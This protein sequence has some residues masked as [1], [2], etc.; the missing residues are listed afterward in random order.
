[1]RRL[2]PNALHILA[3]ISAAAISLAPLSSLAATPTSS[4]APVSP[5]TVKAAFLLNFLRF[6]DWPASIPTGITP[7]LIG[8]S[9]DRGLEDELLRLADRQLLHGRRLR[10][11]R[12]ESPS[13][14]AGLH[15][16]YF[17]VDAA[18]QTETLPAAEALSL[19]HGRPVLTVSDSANFIAAGG[20][21][22][23]FRE[24][25]ALRFEI[26]PDAARQAGLVLSSRLLALANIHREAPPVIS[27]HP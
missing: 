20:M 21:I 9:G 23:I 10:V 17:D 19:L 6:T 22:R 15:M 2:V 18:D 8:V 11:V 5:D 24:S 26:A 3:A 4:L 13:D 12:I 27:R 16:A 1:M 14:L 7:Y 25:G